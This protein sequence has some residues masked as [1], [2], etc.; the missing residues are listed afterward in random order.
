MR[1]VES[2][3]FIKSRARV[4][5][6]L[7]WA[8]SRA[9]YGNGTY[10]DWAHEKIQRFSTC[11][12]LAAN[13]ASY[14]LG[15]R[16]LPTVFSVVVEPVFGCNLR[17]R[18]CWGNGELK[19]EGIRPTLMDWD[20]YAKLV[21]G[22]PRSVETVTFSLAGE[23]L[24]HPGIH[25]MIALAAAH[26]FRTVLFTNGTLL[27]GEK[28]R[29]LCQSPLSVLNV[30]VEP[31]QQDADHYRCG[32]SLAEIREN[33][34]CFAAGKR[35]ET[36]VKLSLVAHGGKPVDVGRIRGEWAGVADAVKVSPEMAILPREACGAGGRVP[37]CMELY[38]G[39]LNVFT[40]GDVSPC[41]FDCYGDLAIGNLNHS[42]FAEIARGEAFR[43][44]VAR[45]KAG[46]AP[47]RCRVCGE[48]RSARA[49]VRAPKKMRPEARRD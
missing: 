16:F 39:N 17:C 5:R 37:D 12:Y 21:P 2:K 49:G 33:V 46:N 48:R 32:S 7:F 42:G 27:K 44:L 11:G 20:L 38:R 24:L 3:L 25:D 1:I 8:A 28:R 35:P 30:S 45:F 15:M 23:P 47:A 13:L 43:A 22:L 14:H 29:Q 18:S 40:N 31:S 6:P 9:L 34:A 36:A 4:L 19:F 41:C 10:A 26:G